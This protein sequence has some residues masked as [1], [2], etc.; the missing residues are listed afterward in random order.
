[1]KLQFKNMTYINI[2][3]VELDERLSLIKI[4]YLLQHYDINAMFKDSNCKLKSDLKSY[5]CRMKNYLLYKLQGNTLAKYEYANGTTS[6]RLYCNESLQ[7][8]NTNARNFLINNSIDID[9]VNCHPTILMNLCKDNNI[10]CANLSL[11][12]NDR[13]N[14]LS[15]I[16][17]EYNET[18]AESKQR[19]L[20]LFYDDKS[21]QENS[22]CKLL[23]CLTNEL[24]TIKAEFITYDEYAFLVSRAKKQ[25][26]LGSFLAHLLQHYENILLQHMISWA[27]TN[28]YG[29]QA[30][31]FD[32]MLVYGNMPDQHLEEMMQYIFAQTNWD[33]KL[34]FKPITTTLKLPENY[35][36]MVR[37]DYET[38]K[39]QFELFNAKVDCDFVTFNHDTGNKI[40]NKA[41]F[42][43]RHEELKYYDSQT[44]KFKDFLTEWFKDW[45]K[46]VYSRFDVYPKEDLCPPGVY[47]LWQPFD[48]A[49]HQYDDE[50]DE[51]CKKGLAYFTNHLYLVSG[52]NESIFN[53]IELWLSQTIQY[54]EH[55]SVEIILYGQEGCGKGLLMQFLQTIFGREKVWDCIDPQNQIFGRFNNL[56]EKAF[57][58][59]L[60]EANK[61]NYFN[62]ND[63]KKA[64]I[65]EP[66]ITIDTKG[67]SSHTINSYHRFISCTNNCDSTVPSE[68]RNCFVEMSNKMVDNT[69][70]FKTG[71]MY[72]NDKNVAKAIY[73]YYMQL[74]TKKKINKEDIPKSEY[75]AEV[76]EANKNPMLLWLY[77]Y[78]QLEPNSH[79]IPT[80]QLATNYRDWLDQ[81]HIKREVYNTRF[82]IELSKLNLIGLDKRQGYAGK[83]KTKGWAI[84]CE[85]LKIDLNV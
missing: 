46:R 2:I 72:A 66:T 69:E 41:N 65:T 36:L 35:K 74:P 59:C 32:G 58:V 44:N 34:T 29:V 77:D 9:I 43:I 56:M 85:Q 64:L 51:L 18:R 14:F 48:S 79:F 25:N 20:K 10:P 21:I 23:K 53:F 81:N 57:I 78:C 27:N 26:Y 11:Y 7:C 4:D 30:L 45:D 24:R 38:V 19:V 61:S 6:G 47:N 17:M 67:M 1:M 70:Y 68:R 15:T 83:I 71:F 37:D 13:N 31:F 8:L 63:K 60:N 55:K 54:P 50:S 76:M 33:I 28:G 39:Q 84:D 73:D 12:C 75:H 40:Y 5:Y 49:T 52:E 80:N 3:M 42:L 82:G 16:Q 62:N 22:K